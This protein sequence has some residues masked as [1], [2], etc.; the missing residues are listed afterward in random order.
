QHAGIGLNVT[1]I[2]GQRVDRLGEA[3]QVEQAVGIDRGCRRIG[4]LVAGAQEQDRAVDGADAVADRQAAVEVERVGRLVEQERAGGDCRHAL[5]L[6]VGGAG[7]L[8]GRQ[9]HFGDAERVDAVGDLAGDRQRI[10]VGADG[11]IVVAQHDGVGP[12]V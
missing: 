5:D 8:Y 3:V 1:V 9:T 7:K 2:D 10:G 4:N 12:G 6:V 11:D